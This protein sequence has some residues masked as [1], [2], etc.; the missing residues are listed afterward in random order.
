MFLYKHIYYFSNPIIITVSQRVGHLLVL[1][2]HRLFDFFDKRNKAIYVSV[3]LR[4]SFIQIKID[5]GG[6]R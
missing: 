2:L 5:E 6:G 4:T 3:Q 1:R